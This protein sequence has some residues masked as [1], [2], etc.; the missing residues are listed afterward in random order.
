MQRRTLTP[1]RDL[2][3]ID[4][5]PVNFRIKLTNHQNNRMAPFLAFLTFIAFFSLF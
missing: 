2:S 4:Q 3:T 1:E 5:P